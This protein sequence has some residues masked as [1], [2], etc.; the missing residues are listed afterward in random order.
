MERSAAFVWSEVLG[1]DGQSKAV[2]SIR[3]SRI[4]R[5][6]QVTAAHNRSLSDTPCL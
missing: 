4:R 5:A 1:P 3:H 2:D 6:S